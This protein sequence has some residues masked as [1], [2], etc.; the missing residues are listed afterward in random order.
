MMGEAIAP[1][2]ADYVEMLLEG[3]E[4]KLVV[5]AHHINVLNLLE[6][7]L[8]RFGL[9]RIDGSTGALRKQTKVDKFIAD[10]SIRVCLG[11][12]QSMGTGTDGL[13]DVCAHA[14][15]IEADW[16]PGVNQQGVDRLDRGGQ[17][18]TV[19]ADFLVAPN[20]FSERL[21]SVSIEKEHTVHAV[22]DRRR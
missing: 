19:Q 9:V 4:D 12:L 8:T 15:F 22:L 16:T 5:F 10:E 20:S 7:R 21:L 14:V 11:N 13:Q 3:G 6:A 17:A 18:G 1:L 2:G